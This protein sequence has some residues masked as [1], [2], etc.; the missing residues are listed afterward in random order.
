MRHWPTS[1]RWSPYGPSPTQRLSHYSV[2]QGH[3][4]SSTYPQCQP[5]YQMNAY[6][7]VAPAQGWVRE[8]P[9]IG[10]GFNYDEPSHI[11]MSSQY[12][13]YLQPNVETSLSSVNPYYTSPVSPRSWGPAQQTSKQ[14][15]NGLYSDYDNSISSAPLGIQYLS[16]VHVST[17]DE[18]TS[19][20]PHNLSSGIVTMDRMLPNP[21]PSRTLTA[22]R[23]N[24]YDAGSLGLMTRN[25]I[26]G[27]V[28]EMSASSQSSGRTLS[29]GFSDGSESN[30]TSSASSAPPDHSL[31]FI[32]TSTCSQEAPTYSGTIVTTAEAR[33]PPLSFLGL[34]PTSIEHGSEPRYSPSNLISYRSGSLGSSYTYGNESNIRH[35]ALEHESY[36]GQL[37]NGQRYTRPEIAFTGPEGASS[38]T[39]PKQ[40]YRQQSRSGHRASLP[41]SDPTSNL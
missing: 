6:P 34:T 21:T 16:P 22:S 5:G 14:T 37:T 25:S 31:S 13:P 32:S 12:P 24:S 41:N 39:S 1:N 28:E 10:Y 19:S 40:A 38:H 27:T 17:G 7:N 3:P 9:E 15:Q 11:Q 18:P 23:I 8:Q 4:V 33:Q 35:T 26:G 29:I 36:A 20:R 30:G 2:P